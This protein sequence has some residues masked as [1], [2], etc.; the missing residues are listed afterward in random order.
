[1]EGTPIVEGDDIIAR[2]D[3]PFGRNVYQPESFEFP[4]VVEEGTW[5]GWTVCD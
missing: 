4:P 5:R 1:M 2:R 3:H